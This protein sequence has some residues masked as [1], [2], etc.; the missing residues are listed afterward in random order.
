V[1]GKPSQSGGETYDEL[2]RNERFYEKL[3]KNPKASDCGV[4]V[5]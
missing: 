3:I 2:T 4:E 1:A 5:Q